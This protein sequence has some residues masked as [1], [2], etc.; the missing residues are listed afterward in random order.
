MA[1]KWHIADVGPS[2]HRRIYS[3]DGSYIADAD[4]N[5]RATQIIREHNSHEA[6]VE[7]LK[8]WRSWVDDYDEGT[9]GARLTQQAEVAL[10]L[11]EEKE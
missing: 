4:N 7:A 9:I 8:E 1:D 5:A 11:A 3:E 10:A 6:L 2:F